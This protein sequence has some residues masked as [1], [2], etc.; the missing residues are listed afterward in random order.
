M[1]PSTNTGHEEN[2]VLEIM[3]RHNADKFRHA[4]K[5]S[6][7][8]GQGYT[9]LLDNGLYCRFRQAFGFSGVKLDPQR[10]ALALC[11]MAAMVEAGDA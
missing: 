5:L 10:R 7:E 6:A 8:K 3:R 9:Y 4:A 2:G 1:S 11:F